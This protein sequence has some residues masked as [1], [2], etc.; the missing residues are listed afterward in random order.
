MSTPQTDNLSIFSIH[1]S[2]LSDRLKFIQSNSSKI[3]THI[4]V[5]TE[6]FASCL[7]SKYYPLIDSGPVYSLVESIT[8]YLLLHYIFMLSGQDL[9]R[10]DKHS[11][12]LH[13][14]TNHSAHQ[15]FFNQALHSYSN[16]NFE[17]CCQHYYAISSF[18]LSR[19]EFCL[20]LEDDS[21]L[22]EDINTFNSILSILR[23][24]NCELIC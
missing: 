15:F 1:Y 8:D 16:A 13:L 24:D 14:S 18:L 2:P 3:H 6:H 11:Y 23:A 19:N 10:F 5:I 4:Q 20:I 7:P 22:L 17:L 21:V 9:S 12:L